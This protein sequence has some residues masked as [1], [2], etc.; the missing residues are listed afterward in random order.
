[1]FSIFR[2]NKEKTDVPKWASFFNKD[3]YHYFLKAIEDYFYS[4]N[5]TYELGDGLLNAG[6]NDFGFSSLGLANVAQV[7]KL[8]KRENYKEIVTGHFNAFIRL[9]QFDKEFKKVI[10]DYDKIKEYIAVRLYPDDY[11]PET[12]KKVSMEKQFAGDIIALL[13]FDLPDSV[14]SITSEQANKWNKTLDELFETGVR[15]IKNKYPLNISKQQFGEFD[16]WFAQG[17]HFFTPNIVFDLETQQKLAG[18]NGS[19]VGIPHRHAVIVY[20][21]ED[22]KVVQA[23]NALIPTV[24]GMNQEGPGSISNNIFW[25]KDGHYENL[26]YEIEEG[27]IQFYPPESFINMLNTCKS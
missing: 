10:D 18:T 6:P 27:K 3:E 1:M 8:D 23:L 12:A 19:L 5:V 24:Y 9:N 7:C 17:E 26:P 11:V 16:I 22:I 2:R 25:Y 14:T 13:V 4:K 15:N 21:I 20:P